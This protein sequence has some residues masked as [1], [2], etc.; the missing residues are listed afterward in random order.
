MEPPTRVLVTPVARSECEND[1]LSFGTL[2]PLRI[3]CFKPYHATCR[4]ILFIGSRHLTVDK[5]TRCAHEQI[6]K[7][8]GYM[9]IAICTSEE[10]DSPHPSAIKPLCPTRWLC[11]LP[12]IQSALENAETGV[13]Q[14]ARKVNGLLD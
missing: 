6:W 5:C 9:F 2:F 8:E 4:D 11:R 10:S 7:V 3:A 13:T 12:A 1:S 14:P